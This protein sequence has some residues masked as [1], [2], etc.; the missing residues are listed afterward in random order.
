MEPITHHRFSVTL[1]FSLVFA[2]FYSDENKLL[3]RLVLKTTNVL[4]PDVTIF[5]TSCLLTSSMSFG[6]PV[7]RATQCM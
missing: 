3:R 1:F 5:K 7:P 6:V 2:F 4:L